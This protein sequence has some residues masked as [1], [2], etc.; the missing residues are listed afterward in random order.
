MV[1]GGVTTAEN[2]GTSIKYTFTATQA[3]QTKISLTIAFEKENHAFILN[4]SFS[5]KIVRPSTFLQPWESGVY[6][7]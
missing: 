7:P 4:F 5:T 2:K 6:S 1:Y 3:L